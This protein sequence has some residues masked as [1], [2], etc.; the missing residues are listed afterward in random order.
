MDVESTSKTASLTKRS[1]Q[2]GGE[3]TQQFERSFAELG[4]AYIQ[5]SAPELI[6]R[7]IGFQLVNRANDNQR[8]FGVFG[9]DLAAH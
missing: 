2:L 6:E 1:D 4:L 3:P 9:F 5:D 8:A 7:L